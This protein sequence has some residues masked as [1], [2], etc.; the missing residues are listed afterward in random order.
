[1][2]KTQ[3][4][5][6]SSTSPHQNIWGYNPSASQDN[7]AKSSYSLASPCP[8]EYV[9]K[10]SSAD[11]GEQDSPVNWVKF[12]YPSSK[13][14]MTITSMCTPVHVACSPLASMDHLLT[15]N[16]HDRYHSFYTLMPVEYIP[17]SI[18]TLCHLLST[19]FHF[20]VD[21][22][23]PTKGPQYDLSGLAPPKGQMTSS[24]IWISLFKSPTPRTLCLGDPTL[25]R[26]NQAISVPM[27]ETVFWAIK[28]ATKPPNT[29]TR[30]FYTSK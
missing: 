19:M 8:Q 12:I 11:L 13:P 30:A 15:I 26:I 28:S 27:C 5:I 23:H 29:K 17:H 14:R 18:P 22:L 10:R 2:L 16:L 24:F 1:M 3:W 25:S 21:Y 7:Q 9:L 4:Q 6:N 20:V